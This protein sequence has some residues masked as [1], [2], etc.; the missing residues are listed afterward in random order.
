MNL[1]KR[2][3]LSSVLLLVLDFIWISFNIN[4]YTSQTVQIQRVMMDVKYIPAILCYV[5]LILGLNYFILNRNRPVW[6]AFL[7]GIIIYG[8]YNTTSLAI[9]KKYTWKV[10]TMDTL[11]GGILLAIT[12][13]VLYCL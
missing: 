2:L 8:V 12:T 3:L 9:Y 10:A 13:A 5:F 7:L 6:E 11:W 4:T 1:Y